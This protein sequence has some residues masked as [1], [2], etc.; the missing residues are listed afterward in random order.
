MASARMLRFRSGV[1]VLVLTLV[2]AVPTTGITAQEET[3]PDPTPTPDRAPSYQRGAPAGALRLPGEPPAVG[4][5]II[6]DSLTFPGAMAG[7]VSCATGKNLGEFVDEGFIVKVSGPCREGAQAVAMMVPPLPGL[8]V[9]DGEIRI[10]AKSVSGHD[11]AGLSLAFRGNSDPLGSYEL[12]VHP[13]QGG[14]ALL[15]GQAD[16]PTIQLALRG[17]L[18]GRLSRD[19]WNEYAIRLDGPNI[20]IL[21][22]GQLI[23]SASDA[24]NDRGWVSFGVHR[25]GS[26]DDNAE[27]AMVFRNLRISRLVND[28]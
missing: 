9:P 4:D 16:A 19:D 12:D 26:F 17:D 11:Q 14:A 24:T 6:E 7:T 28:G 21:L 25:L 23:L 22:N 3:G 27:T 1:L 15:R 10:E 18:A 5:L 2:L 8:V 13:T 20:W